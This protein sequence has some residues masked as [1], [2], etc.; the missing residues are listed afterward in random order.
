MRETSNIAGEGIA[1]FHLMR[2]TSNIAR[3]LLVP[4]C[5]VK[6]S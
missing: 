4:P 6:Q 3:A 2:E 5:N 1:R